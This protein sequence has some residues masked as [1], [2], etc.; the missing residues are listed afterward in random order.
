MRLLIF[1]TSQISIFCLFSYL[2][3]IHCLNL[4]S[5]DSTERILFIA[6]YTAIIIT[7]FLSI[8]AIFSRCTI[9][10]HITIIFLV[11]CSICFISTVLYDNF[12]IKN[13]PFSDIFYAIFSIFV[14]INNIGNIGLILNSKA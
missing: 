9:L 10:Q 4:Y 11:S 2:I 6:S 14:I 12:I 13:T 1:L 3:T 5:I 8:I 7:T